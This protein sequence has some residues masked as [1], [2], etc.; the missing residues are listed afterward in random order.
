M[1]SLIQRAGTYER[2]IED[3]L[4]L[5][6]YISRTVVMV[7]LALVE[8]SAA[9]GQQKI[10]FHHLTVKD[11]LS[12]GGV[13]CILQDSQGFMWFGTQ[14]GLNRY[15]GYEFTVFKHDPADP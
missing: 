2:S 13:N 1:N 9:S 6:S 3:T 12:Q 11:G 4:S 14:D 8:F 5:H 7:L 10:L 15:D